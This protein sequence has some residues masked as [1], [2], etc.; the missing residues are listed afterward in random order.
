MGGEG[1][2][3]SP[4]DLFFFNDTLLVC[5]KYIYCPYWTLPDILDICLA[6]NFAPLHMFGITGQIAEETTMVFLERYTL[7]PVLDKNSLD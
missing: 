6:T 2:I 5:N 7:F 3:F 4:N 1:V